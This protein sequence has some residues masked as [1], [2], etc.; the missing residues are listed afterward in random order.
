MFIGTNVYS[1][2]LSRMGLS[3][4]KKA[5][6]LKVVWAVVL[7]PL[8]FTERYIGIL[9][10]LGWGLGFPLLVIA[11]N[12]RALRFSKKRGGKSKTLD[13]YEDYY[14]KDKAGE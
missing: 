13:L 5:A 3:L 14:K 12:W 8:V 6:Q 11:Y 1:R 2:N 7:V 9:P 10:M 4:M